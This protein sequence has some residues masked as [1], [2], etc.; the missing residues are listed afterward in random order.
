MLDLLAVSPAEAFAEEAL[1]IERLLDAGLVRYHL[2][3][4]DVS[5]QGCAQLLETLPSA[6]R[7]RVVL[8]QHYEL[9]E[10]YGLGGIHVKD[11]DAADAVGARWRRRI[12]GG[13]FSRSLHRIEDLNTNRCEWDAVFLS[14]VFPSLSKAGYRADWTEAALRD[15]VQSSNTAGAGKVYALGGI[16]ATNGPKCAALG[17]QGVVLHGALWQSADP[18]EVFKRIRKVF[19]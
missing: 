7:A 18:V 11:V 2:R 15:A 8:H 6:C 17:F 14:P 4:P 3:K 19:I 9:V 12:E 10:M 13:V 5:V 16:D 1:L